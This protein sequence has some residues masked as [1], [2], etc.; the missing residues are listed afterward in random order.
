M[1]ASST[2]GFSIP[3]WLIDL[4]RCPRC[5]CRLS[6]DANGATCAVCGAA[7]PIRNGIPAFVGDAADEV[8]RRTQSSFGYEWTHFSEWKP[9]GAANFANYF[10]E[11]DLESLSTATVLDAGCGMGRHARFL[12]P[13]AQR[14]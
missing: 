2:V 8:S 10:A 4:L 3:T 14:L 7:T 5:G 12:A 13:Y 11:F 9:S 1:T 6:V